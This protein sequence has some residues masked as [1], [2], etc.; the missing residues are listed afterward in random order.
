M[1]G[2]KLWKVPNVF[3][4]LSANYVWMYTPLSYYFGLEFFL[5]CTKNRSALTA[6]KWQRVAWFSKTRQHWNPFIPVSKSLFMVDKVTWPFSPAT[7][8]FCRVL[9]QLA[10]R[11]S[12]HQ[13]VFGHRLRHSVPLPQRS[14]LRQHR[15]WPLPEIR[16]PKSRPSKE[17]RPGQ[18]IGR[19][20]HGQPL[21]TSRLLHVTRRSS[22]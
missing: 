10:V 3:T 8:T 16:S 21:P 14:G 9:S 15:A 17:S 12:P 11:V 4:N 18:R 13:W 19:W 22:F 6:I 7:I 1:V 20:Q 2:F 5:K